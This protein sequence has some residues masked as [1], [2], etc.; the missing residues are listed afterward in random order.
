MIKDNITD[1]CLLKTNLTSLKR[2]GLCNICHTDGMCTKINTGKIRH[3]FINGY[4]KEHRV[5]R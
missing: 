5:T 4:K 3:T 2:K 1:W